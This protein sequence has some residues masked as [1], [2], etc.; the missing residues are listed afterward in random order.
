MEDRI[1]LSIIIPVYNVEAYLDECMRSI[2]CQTIDCCE[3]ILVDDGSTDQSGKICDRYREQYKDNILVIH[4]ENGGLSSA[5]NAGM[6]EA[7]GDYVAFVDSDDRI[8]DGAISVILQWIDS[9]PADLCFM[10]TMKFFEDGRTQPLGDCISQAGIRGK[11]KEE[12]IRYL[13]TRP[14]YP[15][16]AWSKIYR[17]NFL[18]DNQ[19]EFPKDRRT[20]EDLGFTLDCLIAAES[21]DALDIPYYE[22]RQGRKGSIT[23]CKNAEKGFWDHALFISDS[24]NK[25]SA[26]TAKIII[27]KPLIAFVA[28]EYAIMVSMYIRLQANEKKK[29]RQFLR[30]NRNVMHYSF[31]KELK[32]IRF[33]LCVLGIS[34]TSR[35]IVFY[36]R[37][38]K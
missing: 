33:L 23:N 34:M 14:K 16:A 12:I 13:S 30:D 10:Q 15:G 35:F 29:A 4:K 2:L 20:S 17:R 26:E 38:R 32:A 28:Y 9:S 7:K 24:Q 37:H 3:L 8:A 22:Y 5:R 21:Y 18:I 6:S 36:K 25:F 1:K 11:Q 19:I 27:C 31:T